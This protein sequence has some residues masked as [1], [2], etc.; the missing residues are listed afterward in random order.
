MLSTKQ[1]RVGLVQIGNKFGEQYYLPYSIGLLQAY[2]QKNLKRSEHFTFLVPIY[3]NIGVGKAVDYLFNANIVFFSIYIWNYRISLEIAK[4]IKLK[5]NDSIIVFGGPQIPEEPV[6]LETLLRNNPFIDIACYGEGELPF[7]NILEN[8]KERSWENVQSIGYMFG[9][10]K[11]IYTPLNK[12]INKLDE[13]PSP[14][15]E[16]IFNP[17]IKANSE[18]SWAA[19][20]ETNRGCPFHVHIAIGER[21]AESVYISII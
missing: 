12:R 11:F 18:Q 15:L 3:R 10:E 9:S 1:T 7:L 16:N 6:A 13:I 17:L 5:K 8:I 4:C 21:K 20:L 14:Y 19:L 2:A